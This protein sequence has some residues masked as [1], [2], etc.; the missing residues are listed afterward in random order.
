MNALLKTTFPNDPQIQKLVA[1]S[2]SSSPVPASIPAEVREKIAAL[3]PGMT[4]ADLLK[5]FGTEGGISSRFR[6]TYVFREATIPETIFEK[7][8]VLGVL[9]GQPRRI[10]EYIKVNAQFAPREAH[11][12]WINGVGILINPREEFLSGDA[13]QPNDIIV[14]ISPPYVGPMTLD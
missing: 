12:K 6:R 4:R 8:V 1:K 14:R 2:L 9:I 10:T 7:Q 13:E 11:L 3:Q 5:L